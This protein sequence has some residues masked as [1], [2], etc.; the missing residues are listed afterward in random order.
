MAGKKELVEA[1]TFSRRRL[2]TAFV[3]GAPGGRELEP[4]K[5]LRAVVAGV[6]LSVLLV[7]GGLGLGLLS[8]TLPQGW[9][10]NSL[11][12]TRGAQD[13]GTRYVALDGTL[14]PV[15]NLASA[16]LLVPAGSF[17]VVLVGEDRIAAAPRGATLGI[18]GAPDALPDPARLVPSGWY[19]CTDPAGTTTTRVGSAE[20]LPAALATAAGS[21]EPGDLGLVVRT[22]GQQYLVSGGRWHLLPAASA[23]AVL[24]ELGLE[25]VPAWTVPASWLGLFEPGSDLAPFTVEG[26]G[27]P[28]EGAGAPPGAVVGTVLS[29]TDT[30][31]LY[32]VDAGGGLAPLSPL[33]ARLLQLGTGGGDAPIE[34]TAAQI[35]GMGTSAHVV[36]PADWPAG[37]PTT[38]GP[39]EAACAVLAHEPA[40][41]G[42][43]RV[44]LA[45]TDEVPPATGP[46]ATVE[47]AAGALVRAW[48]GGDGGPVHLLDETGTVYAVPGGDEEVLGRLGYALEDVATVPAGWLLLFP[49]GP[50]LSE[51]AAQRGPVAGE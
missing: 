17:R 2:L 29:V 12:V 35:S 50:E 23:P 11:V 41:D 51:A 5:P 34:V 9:D 39:G 6:G 24:R 8:P 47:P 1:Q 42:A 22:A 33:A 25:S 19:S 16:R 20:A 10:H 40:T 46:T 36:A 27:E 38:P 37:P 43:P 44:V 30:G 15:L 3:S 49:A 26:A 31:R 14:H 18:P 28:L 48:G 7:L 21:E 45:A 32:V 13:G 4:T